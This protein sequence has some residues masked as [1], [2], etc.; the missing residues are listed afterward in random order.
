MIISNGA[1]ELSTALRR[2]S[3]S[4]FQRVSRAFETAVVGCTREIDF[5]RIFPAELDRFL[6]GF[7][8]PNAILACRVSKIHQKPIVSWDTGRCELGDL[9]IVVKYHLLGGIV[10]TKSVIYQVKLTR[11]GTMGFDID[12][13][14]LQLLRE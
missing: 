12:L 8:V 10:E 4:I 3:T 9:L 7:F 11:R 2:R 14:Q 6:S 13:T 1:K 5:L